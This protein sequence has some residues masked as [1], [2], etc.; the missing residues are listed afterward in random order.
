MTMAA[1]AFIA[2]ILAISSSLSLTSDADDAC[3]PFGPV[4]KTLFCSSFSAA[5]ASPPMAAPPAAALV[6]PPDAGAAV[7]PVAPPDAGAVVAPPDWPA[8]LPELPHPASPRLI[9][10]STV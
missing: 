8:V 1:V 10:R 3:S 6:A 9:A 7:A 4:L 5:L 2:L